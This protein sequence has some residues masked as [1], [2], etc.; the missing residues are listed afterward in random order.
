[1]LEVKESQTNVKPV[2]VGSILWIFAVA[3]GAIVANTYYCQPI[4]PRVA[5]TFHHSVASLTFVVTATQLGY[6]VSLAF[7]VPLG[8]LVRRKKLIPAVFAVAGLGCALCAIAPSLTYLLIAS[9]IVGA[10]SVGGQILVPFVADFAPT[11]RRSRSIALLMSGLLTGILL[12]RTF[13][14]LVAQ[15]LGWRSVYFASMGIML[16]LAVV[17]FLVIPDEPKRDHG[18]YGRL[19]VT[20]AQLLRREPILLRRSVLG[21]LVFGCFTVFWS[22]FSWQVSKPPFSYNSFT[23]GLFGIIGLSGVIAANTVG[24]VADRHRGKTITYQVTVA[25]AAATL[26]SFVFFILGSTS[27]V[28]IVFGVILLDA[29]TQGVQLSNQTLIYGLTTAS[30]SRIT[31]AYMFVYFLGGTVGSALTGVALEHSGWRASSTVGL[32][33]GVAAVGISIAELLRNRNLADAGCEV[34]VS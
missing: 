33:L 25:A 21:A 1:M 5:A 18:N 20:T 13:S 19:L 2:L 26:A 28:V 29:G 24:R 23:I 22:S 34:E 16:V 30:R 14:G 9:V 12:A 6:A 31:S 3:T 32:V 8:D 4:L 17:L 10:A 15:A 7:I 27:I 11:D